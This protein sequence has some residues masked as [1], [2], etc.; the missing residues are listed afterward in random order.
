M[1]SMYCP[2]WCDDTKI[3]RISY[4]VVAKGAAVLRIKGS[5]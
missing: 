3:N 1:N 4:D 5:N 2:L